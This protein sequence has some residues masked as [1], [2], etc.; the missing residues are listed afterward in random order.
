MNSAARPD[1]IP[2]VVKQLGIVSFC[3]D[4]ASEMVYPLLPALVTTKLGAGAVSLGALDGISEAMSAVV[5]WFSGR[6]ADRAGWRRPLVIAGYGLAAL[7]RPV[8]GIAG[9]AWHVIGLRATDRLG[10]GARTPPRDAVI[11]DATRPDLRGR[12]FGYHRGMDHAGAVAGPLVAWVMIA[13]WN[14]TPVQVILGSAIPGVIAIAVVTWAM[15]LAGSENGAGR[16]HW[17]AGDGRETASGKRETQA[18]ST[19]LLFGLIVAFAFARFP[20]T[21]LLLRMQ[22]LGVAVALMPVAWGAM[23][24]I[25]TAASYPG[26]WLS[27]RVGPRRTMLAGWLL[28]GGVCVGLATAESGGVA[29]GWFLVYGLVAPATE[30]PERAFIAAAAGRGRQGRGFGAYHASVG[31]AALPGSLL[32]G[33][34]YDRLGAGTALLGSATVAGLLAIAAAVASASPRQGR[35]RPSVAGRELAGDE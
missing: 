16:V 35:G 11:A 21:L 27:D 9:A 34:L 3:N 33:A 30:A 13:G 17:E 24:L 10:K 20:E 19:A 28:Y 6:L 1:R 5:K 31:I 22:E 29:F 8:M 32:F 26:G 4:L 12:A 7:S 23:H 14:A 18:P 2:A 25:R 15:Q